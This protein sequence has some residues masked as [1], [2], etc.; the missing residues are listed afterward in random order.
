MK[1]MNITGGL[2]ILDDPAPTEPGAVPRTEPETP[3][4]ETPVPE[5]PVPET[6][7]SETPVPAAPAPE[8]SASETPAPPKPDSKKPETLPTRAERL[9]AERQFNDV[10][11]EMRKH[12]APKTSLLESA[13]AFAFAKHGGQRRSTGELYIT[14]PIAVA[15]ILAEGGHDSD[16]IAAALLHDVVEDCGVTIEE[17][18]EK[19]GPAVAEM[20]DTVTKVNDYIE[21]NK[22]TQK[23]DMD[24]LSDQKFLSHLAS[25][26]NRNGV[27]IKCADRIHNLTTIDSFPEDQ[28]RAKAEHTRSV[29]IPAAQHLGACRLAQILGSLC[30]KIENRPMY[31]AIL[32]GYRD[33]RLKNHDTLERK[34]G[35]IDTVKQMVIEDAALGQYIYGFDFSERYADD[36]LKEINDKLV[37]GDVRSL[38]TKKN[39]PVFDVYFSTRQT[40][41]EKP[42]TVF[43]QYYER[44]HRSSY[45]FTIFKLEK[46]PETGIVF[47]KMKDR[48]DNIYR[49]Y[50]QSEEEHLKFMHGRILQGEPKPAE[51]QDTDEIGCRKITVYKKDN[52]P[53]RI[54]EGAS[55]LDFAFLLNPNIGICAKYAF[56]NDSHSRIQIHQRLRPGD[57]V[58]IISDHFKD[59]PAS[60][61]PHATV[62]WFEYLRTP[63][64]VRSLT[65]WLEKNLESGATRMI[66]F[67]EQ[68]AYEIPMASTVLDFAFVLGD[69]VGLHLKRAY[70]NKSDEPADFGRILR[71]GDNVRLE[72]DREDAHTPVFGWLNLVRTRYAREK[73]IQYFDR[74]YNQTESGQGM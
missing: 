69:E 16:V 1:D 18:E 52:T 38:M 11:E 53:A 25:G 73:L 12:G 37:D 17:L 57:K 46:D 44:L 33:M 3:A 58:E 23:R 13:F 4:S 63:E 71:Y 40:C 65:R 20:V 51:E 49:L 6:S 60:D 5:T 64:A 36:I 41:P 22:G 27:F 35:L 50:I 70:I 31:D 14:H 7:A 15:R 45:R 74:L 28:K 67:N 62:R 29:I 10:L 61:I 26:H 21:K 39:V 19:F 59:D 55:V 2:V 32:E 9:E 56:L 30:L 66:V 42:E 34:G 68:K 24:V 47:Y 48:Y 72:Y 43:F 54:R 8:T